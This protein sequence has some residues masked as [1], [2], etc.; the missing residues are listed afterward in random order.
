MC[1][2]IVAEIITKKVDLFTHTMG[3][4]RKCDVEFLFIQDVVGIN[5]NTLPKYAKVFKDTNTSYD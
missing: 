1:T 5:T 4:G 2:D 3:S